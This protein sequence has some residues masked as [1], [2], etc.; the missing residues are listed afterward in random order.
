MAIIDCLARSG[1]FNSLPQSVLESL[2]PF[3]REQ[4]FKMGEYIFREGQRA[5]ELYVVTSGQVCWRRRLSGP[6]GVS[7]AM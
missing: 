1:I 5:D 2:L 6:H 3:C 7:K 4:S